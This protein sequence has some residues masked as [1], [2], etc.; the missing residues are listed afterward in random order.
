MSYYE[1]TYYKLI[2]KERVKNREVFKAKSLEEIKKYLVD[3]KTVIEIGECK[4][5]DTIH[6]NEFVTDIEFENYKKRYNEL[7]NKM[8]QVLDVQRYNEQVISN[9]EKELHSNREYVRELHTQQALLRARNSTLFES[10][11][12]LTDKLQL[13]KDKPHWLEITLGLMLG[14]AISMAFLL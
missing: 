3:D 8:C 5:R 1:V 2:K 9:K 14:I 4:Y 7:D 12:E 6:D 10:R 13:E 11:Q